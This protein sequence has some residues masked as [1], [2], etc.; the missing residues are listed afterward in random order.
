MNQLQ[1]SLLLNAV[2]S[3]ISGVI[4]VVFPKP[5]A[6]IFKVSAPEIF[7][8]IGIALLFFA[9]TIFYELRK[10]RL[11]AVLWIITQDMLWVL[12]SITL[13]LLQPFQ[14]SKTGN[15][16]IAII[17]LIVLFMAINQTKAI[18]QVDGSNVKGQKKFVFERIV[19]ASK[20]EVW[21]VISDVANYHKVAPNI[22]DVKILEGSGEGMVRKCS[23]KKDSWTETCTLWREEKMYSFIVN[24]SAPDYPYKF[25]KYLKGTWEVREIDSNATKILMHFEFSYKHKF[26][27]VLLHPFLK[28]KFKKTGKKLLDNWQTLLE[29]K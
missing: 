24:T 29:K 5:I 17:A 27:N 9:G 19:M 13:I 16:V 3:C 21:A 26:Q 28:A 15:S 18:A 25:L 6:V 23:H 1:K 10:Q 8:L 12:T 14:I 2:F 4:L 22:T 7:R 20:K 11:V